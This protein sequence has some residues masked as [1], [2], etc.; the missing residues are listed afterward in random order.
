MYVSSIY[1]Q[2][3]LIGVH[4][5]NKTIEHFE[6]VLALKQNSTIVSLVFVFFHLTVHQMVTEIIATP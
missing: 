4:F 1:I 2:F 5:K 6:H 3:I